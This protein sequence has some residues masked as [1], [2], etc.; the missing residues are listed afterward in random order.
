VE[1]KTG[2]ATGRCLSNGGQEVPLEAPQIQNADFNFGLAA[3]VVCGMWYVVYG[4]IM[5]CSVYTI[6]SV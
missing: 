1:R 4:D 6:L 2:V 5:I 3:H